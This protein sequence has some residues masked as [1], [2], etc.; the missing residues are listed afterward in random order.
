MTSGAFMFMGA[1]IGAPP[2][3]PLAQPV[4]QLLPQV[5]QLSQQ[6]LF[7]LQRAFR[8]ANRP[9]LPQPL[10]QQSWQQVLQETVQAGLQHTGAAQQT[11]AGL[12]QGVG[13]QVSQ[14]SFFLNLPHIRLKKPSLPQPLSQQLEAWQVGAGWQQV[15]AAWQH[16][17]E[18]QPLSQQSF[19]LKRLQRRAN[20]P[21]FSSQ[22]VPQS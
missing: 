5:L 13:A 10:S 14:Q 8:R 20:R 3:E 12:Q 7:F 9:G 16:E 15:G 4:P 17:V 6:S 19:F 18:P 11:G 1:P 22:Q 2:H 21:G